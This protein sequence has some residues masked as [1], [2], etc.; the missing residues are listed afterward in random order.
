MRIVIK[1]NKEEYGTMADFVR[2][3]SDDLLLQIAVVTAN[4]SAFD[5]ERIKINFIK[6]TNNEVHYAI[7]L[8]RRKNEL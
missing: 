8:H 4:W 1:F 3:I 5:R 2:I 6:I 7:G